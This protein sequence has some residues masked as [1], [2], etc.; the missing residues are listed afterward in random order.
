[1]QKVE[2]GSWAG[3]QTDL[4]RRQASYILPRN[5]GAFACKIGIEDDAVVG[6][7]RRAV[8]K[9]EYVVVTLSD[10][11]LK[12]TGYREVAHPSRKLT[13]VTAPRYGTR[14]GE[15]VG[16]SEAALDGRFANTDMHGV[17]RLRIGSASQNPSPDVNRYAKAL[18]AIQT[19]QGLYKL[20]GVI[21]DTKGRT[22]GEEVREEA[23][24]MKYSSQVQRVVDLARRNE[25]APGFS[26]FGDED[27]SSYTAT[28][29]PDELVNYFDFRMHV[30]ELKITLERNF[31]KTSSQVEVTFDRM[32]FPTRDYRTRMDGRLYNHEELASLGDIES[33]TKIM[34]HLNGSHLV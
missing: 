7:Q 10:N 17:P 28:Y 32:N 24:M 14:I 6:L 4:L 31:G 30:A 26:L 9:S 22:V 1:M 20:K 16:V 2:E 12:P 33:L 18:H 25:K 34:S 8:G 13:V 15:S 23:A 11:H 21:L 27:I 29:R 5:G 3:R 19:A